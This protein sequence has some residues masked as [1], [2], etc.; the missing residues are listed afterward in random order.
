MLFASPV[1]VKHD[2]AIGYLKGGFKSWYAAGKEI[3]T[4]KRITAKEM[5]EKYTGKD[6]LVVDI[7]KK[8]EYDS[9]H[10]IN[11]VNIP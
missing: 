8:S 11:A 6:I 4:V 10:L 3:E 2:H 7:R 5:E 9:E 1:L